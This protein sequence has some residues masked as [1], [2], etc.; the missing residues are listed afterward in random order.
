MKLRQFYGQTESSAFNALQDIEEVR[1]H[2][3][4]KPLP[5]VEVKIGDNGEIMVRSEVCFLVTSLK[6]PPGKHLRWLVAHGRC[7][8]C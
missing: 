1:L 3:V 6:M 2:T 7:W 8:L 5:G 4:G